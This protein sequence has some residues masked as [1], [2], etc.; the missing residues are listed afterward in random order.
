MI[1]VEMVVHSRRYLYEDLHLVGKIF[2]LP[3]SKENTLDRSILE[4]IATLLSELRNSKSPQT[5]IK[6]LF[7]K[8]PREISSTPNSIFSE[9]P[10]DEIEYFS[11]S[12]KEIT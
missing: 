10:L 3:T 11:N 4:N 9:D 12:D 5:A 7:I 8:H 6:P 1:S 2:Q